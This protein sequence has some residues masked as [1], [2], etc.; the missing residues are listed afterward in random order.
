ME[1][2]IDALYQSANEYDFAIFVLTP[3][4]V[5]QSRGVEFSC[6]RDNVMFEFAMFLG[7]IGPDRTTA[8]VQQGTN[9][10]IPSDLSGVTIPR[11]DV[12]D[13]YDLISTANEACKT[14][15]MKIQKHGRKKL[16]LLLARTWKFNSKSRGFEVQ[17][18]AERL[19]RQQKIL[20]DRQL[21][22]A[23]R[24]AN[25]EVDFMEDEK[26]TFGRLRK[27]PEMVSGDLHLSVES[28]M[29]NEYD[30][31]IAP[32]KIESRMLLVPN[33]VDI[34]QAQTFRQALAGGCYEMESMSVESGNTIC[35]KCGTKAAL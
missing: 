2:T 1:T 32:S 29:F 13:K 35:P 20:G 18:A 16:D 26:V 23:A 14:M 12:G 33:D 9:V 19:V 6:A 22:V 7:A 25:R 21:C 4:D 34:K 17:I 28:D 3:D 31:Q 8:V 10:K 11:F 30:T 24:I 15:M 27:I 5:L